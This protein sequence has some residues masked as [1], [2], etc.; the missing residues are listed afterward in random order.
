MP[1]VTNVMLVGVGGQGT[2]L[3]S[4]ILARGLLAAGYDVKMSEVHG[5]AQ[6][7][8]SVSTTVR[9]G[10]AVYSP[11]ISPGQADV[12][13]SFEAMEALRWLSYV[14]PTGRVVVNDQKI[15]SAPILSGRCP[16]P[17]GVIDAVRGKVTTAVVEAQTI[18]DDLGNP[19]TANVVLLGALV[20]NLGLDTVDWEAAVASTVKPAFVDINLAALRAGRR[21]APH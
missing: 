1:N 15:A 18:A 3:V 14:K 16:Y 10:D 8:G 5:M 9:F 13:V 19:R 11:I 20:E 4:S 17:D 6:R 7:G 2:I 21:A 12:L